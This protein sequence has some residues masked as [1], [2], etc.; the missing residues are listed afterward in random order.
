MKRIFTIGLSFLLLLT[1]AAGCRDPYQNI[2]DGGDEPKKRSLFAKVEALTPPEVGILW[3]VSDTLAVYSDSQS[4]PVTFNIQRGLGSESAEFVGTVAGKTLIALC[5]YSARTDAGL[6]GKELPLKLP[7]VQTYTKGGVD[8]RGLPTVAVSQTDDVLFKHLCGVLKL[9]VTGNT[10]LS[11]IRLTA[12]NPNMK[13][14]GKAKFRTD[15][16]ET[17][18]LSMQGDA[19]NEL[20]LQCK[21]GVVLQE[22]EASVFYVA[23]PPGA[24]SGGFSLEIITFSGTVN[25]EMDTALVIERAKITS[26][27]TFEC[28][29]EGTAGADNV[30]Y[31]QIWYTTVDGSRI[32]V[33]KESCDQELLS[34]EYDEDGWGKLTF[35]GPVTQIG[36]FAFSMSKLTDIRLPDCVESLGASSFSNTAIESFRT[37][38]KLSKVGR[39]AFDSSR[40]LTRFYGPW[41]SADS[42]GIILSEGTLVSYAPGLLDGVIEIPEGTR[43]LGNYLFNRDSNIREVIMPEGLVKIGD[44]VFRNIPKLERV[45]LSGTVNEVGRYAFAN[46]KGLS[47]FEGSNNMI[48][49]GGHALVDADGWLVAVAINGVTDYTVPPEARALGSGVLVGH[50]SLQSITFTTQLFSAYNDAISDCPGLEFFYGTGTTEDHHGLVIPDEENGNILV[51]TTTI[52]P[53]E[54]TVPE[55]ISRVFWNAFQDN[56]STEKLVIPDAVYSIGNFCFRGMSN[57]KIL[58]LPA[59]L[60]EVGSKAFVY[61]YGLEHLY[62]RSGYPPT[63]PKDDEDSYFGHNGLTIHVPEDCERYYM[64]ADGWSDYARYI[65]PYRYTD[66]PESEIYHSTDFSQ[67]GKVTQLQRATKG[68]GINVVLMGDAFSDRQMSNGFYDKVMQQM[69]TAFFSEEPFASYRDMFNVYAVKVVSP[70]EGYR[71]NGQALGTWFGEGTEVGGNKDKCLAYAYKAISKADVDNALVIVAMNSTKYAGTCDLH[72]SGS[73][74]YGCGLG[75]AYLPICGGEEV[76]AQVLNHE[77][78]GH[79]FAKLA[80]EYSSREGEIPAAEKK[81]ITD[82]TP[83]GWWKNIDLT[84]SAQNVKWKH[85]LQDS[86]YKNDGL[87]CFQGAWDYSMGAWRAT[88]QSIMR[89]NEGGFNAPSREAIWYRLHK[90]AYGEEWEYS[91]EDFVS[92]DAKNRKSVTKA[93]YNGRQLPPLPAPRIIE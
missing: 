16:A 29:P 25:Y 54:Y 45:I 42:T 36:D 21:G 61:C 53:R 85:F 52:L 74:D 9:S 5:P 63:Y 89:Y 43:A 34:N 72:I 46:C 38:E 71:D 18:F 6:K 32:S 33:G 70:S 39:Y 82:R 57:L 80:D 67:D 3:W 86:R 49:D 59:S 77:A 87:G 91:Y 26:A 35:G 76:F 11:S 28:K 69:L 60:Q 8:K 56:V 68:K 37:P 64:A 47:L 51:R 75:V 62:L 13:I 88:E 66:L 24:Y 15:Y 50:P 1:L 4:Q 14:S 7:A 83:Y 30:P 84:G 22:N 2:D 17:P 27:P 65:K 40:K 55:G 81:K 58:Q 10:T 12:K 79:G 90:L 92:Y 19:S 23:L 73:G 41:A 44:F 78:G 20:T 93:S 31:N 48:C